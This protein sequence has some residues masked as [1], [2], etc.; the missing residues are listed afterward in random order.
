MVFPIRDMRGYED[1]TEA[2]YHQLYG[3][4]K[5]ALQIANDPDLMLTASQQRLLNAASVK[6]LLTLRKPRVDRDARP[7]I[8]VLQDDKLAI[9]ENLQA[10]PRAYMVYSSTVVPDGLQAAKDALLAPDHDPRRSVILSGGDSSLSGPD[11]DITSAPVS[12]LRDSPEDVE[13]SVDA[14][15]PGYL[16]LS[17]NF[18]SGWQAKLDGEPAG[19]QRANATFRAVAVPPGKHTVSFEY[20]PTLFYVGAGI[21]AIAVLVLLSIPIVY[22][23]RKAKEPWSATS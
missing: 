1:L 3:Q 20:R 2:S 18:A 23:L 17:D 9:Y 10:L 11:L 22:L 14:P 6:Y 12:W 15:A 8:S 21:S 7:Y 16:V 13:L 19:I 4:F 5:G